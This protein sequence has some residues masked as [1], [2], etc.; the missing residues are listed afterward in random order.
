MEGRDRLGGNPG[1]EAKV[2]TQSREALLP[3]LGR[4]NQAARR[5]RRMQFTALLHHVDLE[6]LSRAFVR[7][8]RSASAGVDGETVAHYE[9]NLD[10]NLNE[11]CERVHTGRYRPLPVRRVYIPKSDG[12]KR[13]LGIPALED[14]IVQGAVAE[15]LS[16]IYEV[17]FV[18]FSYGFRPGRNAHEA[19]DALH[20]GM[21]TQS[22]NWVLDA[23]IRSFFDSVDH[24]WLLR[25]VAVRVADPRILRLIRLWLKAGV[26]ESGEW[27]EC[28]TGT[29]Q[30]SAISPLLANIFLHYA[31]DV[32]VAIWRRKH[33][34][35]RVVI[36]RYA[37]DFV[38]GF[39]YRSDAK[40]MMAALKERLGRFGLRL[41]EEKT[42]LIEF[43]RLPAIDHAQSGERRLETFNFLGFTHYC[44]W[45]R[46]GRFVVK[47]KTQSKRITRKLK[48]LREEARRRM[49]APVAAQHEWLRSVLRGHY[50]YYGLPCNYPALRTFLWEVR[51]IWYR[52]LRQRERKRRLSWQ[53]FEQL[54]QRWPLPTPTITHPR[55]S[56]GAV[57]G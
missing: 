7:L 40:T 39:Q 55:R 35:G 13:P 1:D 16:A 44:G 9:Q 43:G 8:R 50:A 11:L 41:H 12:G 45:T 54:L 25:M 31:L 28:E 30:G 15:M 56:V 36:V 21:M 22:V 48:E 42:R 34:R 18:E 14:K 24:E 57:L 49:H 27:M 2:R 51:R 19:L 53:G 10:E 5:D 47:R 17:D 46:D 38:M 6:S 26:L 29:P 20:T 23:D 33:A 37:D 32:W 52:A 4:V 3:N